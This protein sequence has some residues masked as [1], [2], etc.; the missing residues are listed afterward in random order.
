M[1][2]EDAANSEDIVILDEIKRAKLREVRKSTG[3]GCKAPHVSI[4]FRPLRKNIQPK[5]VGGRNR[6]RKKEVECYDVEDSDSDS[7]DIQVLEMDNQL[8]FVDMSLDEGAEDGFCD[9]CG[10]YIE[11]MTDMENHQENFHGIVM[12]RWCQ[13]RMAGEDIKFHIKS[14]CTKFSKLLGSH[15]SVHNRIE[16][17]VDI[18][19]EEFKDC[20]PLVCSVCDQRYDIKSLQEY[21]K[22]SQGYTCPGCLHGRIKAPPPAE[23][24]QACP[25]E[26]NNAQNNPLFLSDDH[27]K[28]N[29]SEVPEIM[30]V[31]SLSEPCSILNVNSTPAEDISVQENS[32]VTEDSKLMNEEGTKSEGLDKENEFQTNKDANLAKDQEHIED[33]IA[34]LSVNQDS[35]DQ[36]LSL[37]RVA[38]KSTRPPT[39]PQRQDATIEEM[40]LL[41]E[42]CNGQDFQAEKSNTPN[43]DVDS[44][45]QVE[46]LNHTPKRKQSLDSS[47]SL[48]KIARKSTKP[49]ANPQRTFLESS[50]DGTEVR[51]V[52]DNKMEVENSPQKILRDDSEPE[53]V[54][55]DEIII[56]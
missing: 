19:K 6:Y 18:K 5:A 23:V 38:R 2:S 22:A 39:N 17:D 12:C 44:L 56:S 3:I 13:E 24:Q 21:D 52:L 53:V 16:T 36:N 31:F 50:L 9:T 32:N 55:L 27:H 20:R 48:R 41:D 47:G 10:L 54:E 34:V 26:Q 37:R 14:R 25:E 33:E 28:E 46:S 4:N 8:S 42:S 43:K 35:D 1:T 30:N 40:L 7:D 45:D 11:N 29:I 15:C 51:E 49:P